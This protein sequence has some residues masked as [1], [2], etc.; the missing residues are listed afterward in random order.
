MTYVL[1]VFSQL[2]ERQTYQ[3]PVLAVEYTQLLPLAFVSAQHR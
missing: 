1:H 3:A 2:T